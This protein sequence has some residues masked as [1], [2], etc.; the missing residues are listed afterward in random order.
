MLTHDKQKKPKFILKDK[1][2]STLREN[3][4]IYHDAPIRKYFNSPIKGRTYTQPK[5]GVLV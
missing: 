1:R 2:P 5:K 3:K 4:K